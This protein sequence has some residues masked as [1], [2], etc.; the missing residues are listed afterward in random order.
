VAATGVT[1]QMSVVVTTRHRCYASWRSCLS[2]LAHIQR[3]T[4]MRGAAYVW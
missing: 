3:V 2:C 4:G 1:I